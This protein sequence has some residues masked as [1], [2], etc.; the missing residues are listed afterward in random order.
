MMSRIIKVIIHNFSYSTIFL[1]YYPNYPTH[2]LYFGEVEIP[3]MAFRKGKSAIPSLD[4]GVK[5][6]IISLNLTHV[7]WNKM[8]RLFKI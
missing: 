5:S 1:N 7:R 4:F 2:G 3:Y 6:D 8:F